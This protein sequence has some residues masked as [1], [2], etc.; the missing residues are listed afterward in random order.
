MF[1]VFRTDTGLERGIMKSADRASHLDLRSRAVRA[2]I[3]KLESAVHNAYASK[4]E[5]EYLHYVSE[6]KKLIAVS[7]ELHRQELEDLEHIKRAAMFAESH[8]LNDLAELHSKIGEL[9]SRK[10]L[11]EHDAR[12]LSG[13]LGNVRSDLHSRLTRDKWRE[14]QLKMKSA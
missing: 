2:R 13:K 3:K 11:A 10:I 7:I 1:G 4:N 8:K 12:A 6:I 9:K 14:S 5:K